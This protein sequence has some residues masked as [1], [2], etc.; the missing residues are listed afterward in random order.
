MYL[1]IVRTAEL[2]GNPIGTD[3]PRCE[4]HGWLTMAAVVFVQMR[5]APRGLFPLSMSSWHAPPWLA[6]WVASPAPLT[7][8]TPRHKL[9]A[10]TPLARLWCSFSRKCATKMARSLSM[11]CRTGAR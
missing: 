3:R 6:L 10:A 1:T 2:F 7:C 9:V 4:R 11:L 5:M 8:L